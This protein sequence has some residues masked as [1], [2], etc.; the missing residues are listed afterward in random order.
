ML[1]QVLIGSAMVIIT[2]IIH[3]GGMAVSLRWITMA[4]TK[5]LGV[6]T[7]LTRSLV[8]GVLILIMFI[9][10][11]FEAGVWALTYTVVG[12]I[13]EFEK[14][15]YFST[16]TYTT[17]GYGDVVLTNKWRLLSSFE[18]ANGIIMF[19]WTTALII[20]GIHQISRSL[21]KLDALD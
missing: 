18:A 7:I 8:V 10:T 15:L 5:R 9:A 19:G 11:L 4:H 12:A 14:A 17:L 1:I 21:R 2:A 20:V 13:T 16:V 3:A 6:A